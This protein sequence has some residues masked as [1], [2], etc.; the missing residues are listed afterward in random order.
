MKK[1]AYEEGDLFAIPLTERQFCVGLAARV[2][3]AQKVLCGYYFSELFDAIPTIDKLPRWQ[4]SDAVLQRRFGDLGLI[5]G[6]WPIFGKCPYWVR[7]EWSMSPLISE[8]A[9]TDSI[10]VQEYSDKNPNEVIFR[11]I[12]TNDDLNFPKDGV[13]GYKAIVTQLKCLL[14]RRRPL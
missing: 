10:W 6:E 13:S 8:E 14:P 7:G 2:P 9:L 5:N 1:H 12:A 3:K 4:P 11:R